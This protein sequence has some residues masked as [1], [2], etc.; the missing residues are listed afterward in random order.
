MTCLPALSATLYNEAISGDLSNNG[1][2]PTALTVGEGSNQV[3]GTTGNHGSGLDRDYFTI[4]V[5][6]GYQIGQLVELAGTQVGANV[7]FIGLEA[8]PQVTVPPNAQSA[9]GLLGWDHYSPGTSDIDLLSGI[10]IPSNGSSGFSALPSGQYSFWI[11]DFNSGTFAYAFDIR[12]TPTPEPGTY[13]TSLVVLMVLG[14]VTRKR[15]RLNK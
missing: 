8:G 2:A 10:S 12:L 11:Q 1:L 3:F 4:N 9:A 5:P 7:S 15:S 14:V 13:A 6:T